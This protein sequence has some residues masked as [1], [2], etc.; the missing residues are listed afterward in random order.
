MVYVLIQRS[1][2]AFLDGRHV[3]F[4]VKMWLSLNELLHGLEAHR[5]VEMSVQLLVGGKEIDL[6]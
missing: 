4:N 6:N 3:V 2:L 1:A 5:A